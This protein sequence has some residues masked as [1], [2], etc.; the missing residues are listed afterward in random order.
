MTISP[1]GYIII[2]EV[3]STRLRGKTVGL[4]RNAYNLANII[5]YFVSPYAL[6]PTKGNWKG[7]AGALTGGLIILCIVWTWFRLP[8][9]KGRTYGE[10]DILFAR[11]LKTREFKRYP[12][13]VVGHE[14]P[15]SKVDSA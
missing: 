9:T 7:K 14:G 6:N 11:G 12:V 1:I 4:A 3:S 2:G 13:D 15:E 10:L 8:E 5:N